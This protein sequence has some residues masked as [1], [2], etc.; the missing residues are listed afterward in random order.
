VGET[1]EQNSHWAASSGQA[2]LLVRLT[3]RGEGGARSH[4]ARGVGAEFEKYASADGTAAGVF[5]FAAFS[6]ARS[7]KPGQQDP[8]AAE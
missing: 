8:N 1:S 7:L 4:A 6:S 5:A 2:R 3:A